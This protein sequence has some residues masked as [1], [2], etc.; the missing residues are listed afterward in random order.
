LALLW[1][2]AHDAVVAV[3]VR[4]REVEETVWPLHHVSNAPE[5]PAEQGF[6]INDG[7]A[8]RPRELHA[9]HVVGEIV[10]GQAKRREE[11][12]AC[13]LRMALPL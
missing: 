1:A 10:A 11:E 9:V 3:V 4:C 2:N 6:F 5:L 8:A 13:P 12:G 7:R